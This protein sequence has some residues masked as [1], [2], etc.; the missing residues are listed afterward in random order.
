MTL[1]CVRLTKIKNFQPDKVI[2]T[3]KVRC[4]LDFPLNQAFYTLYHLTGSTPRCKS[5]SLGTNLK[6][7]LEHFS[8][9]SE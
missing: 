2:T 7:V 8:Q 1:D 3:L 9:N 5:N 4:P 6:L